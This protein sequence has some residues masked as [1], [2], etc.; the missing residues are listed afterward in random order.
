[1]GTA[2]IC[3]GTPDIIWNDNSNNQIEFF[4]QTLAEDKILI[5][6]MPIKD[7]TTGKVTGHSTGSVSNGNALVAIKDESG[8]ILWSWHLWFWPL[9][10]DLPTEAYP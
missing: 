6:I 3:E 2:E 4:Q 1:M 7:A 8:K 10:S 5:D 9:N